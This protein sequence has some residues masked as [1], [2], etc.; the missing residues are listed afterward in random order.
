MAAVEARADTVVI[1]SGSI[2]FNYQDVNNA[3][4]LQGDGFSLQG[5]AYFF[6]LGYTF[7]DTNFGGTAKLGRFLDN[8]DLA[9]STPFTVGGV[10]YTSWQK[11]YD[12]V[13][14]NITAP[15]FAFPTDPSVM[16]MTFSSPFTMQGGIMLYPSG[17][18]TTLTGQGIATAMFARDRNYSQLWYLRTLNYEFQATPTPEP[19]TL[20]LLGTGIAGVA[21]RVRRR[22]KRREED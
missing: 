17:S 20:L 8:D 5:K 12:G 18:Q 14:L 4:S 15:E 22:K 2:A 1:T 9:V 16:E 19:A 11:M 21:A 3:F 10:T 13:F 7:N 6:Y